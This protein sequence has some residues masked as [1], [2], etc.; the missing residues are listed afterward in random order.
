VPSLFQRSPDATDATPLDTRPRL[1]CT[2]QPQERRDLTQLDLEI[3]SVDRSHGAEA[4]MHA[5]E[6]HH[7]NTRRGVGT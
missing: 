5:F 1:A 7:V 2:V 4:A 6:P 3:N